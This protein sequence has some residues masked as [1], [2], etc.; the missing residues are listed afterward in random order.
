MCCNKF[1]LICLL[2]DFTIFSKVV[3]SNGLLCLQIH[4]AISLENASMFGSEFSPSIEF[5][6]PLLNFSSVE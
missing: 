6:Q 2:D 1:G 4:V 3:V 5:C